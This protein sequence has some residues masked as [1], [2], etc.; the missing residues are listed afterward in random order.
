MAI[1]QQARI[2]RPLPLDSPLAIRRLP[3]VR[4]VPWPTYSEIMTSSILM[5]L[6]L[7][8]IQPLGKWGLTSERILRCNAQAVQASNAC[9]WHY[10]TPKL[11]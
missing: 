8:V 11:F 3:L 4:S 9:Y 7:G 6:I 5:S 2:R 1:A 10:C